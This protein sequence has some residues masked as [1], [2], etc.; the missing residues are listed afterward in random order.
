MHTE[1][2]LLVEQFFALLRS[3]DNSPKAQ[4]KLRNFFYNM[5]SM[6]H[7]VP[8]TVEFLTILKQLKPFLHQEFIH[9][10]VPNS[11]IHMMAHID[12]DFKT[13]L[14]NLGI[15]SD[16]DLLQQLKNNIL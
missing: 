11:R 3:L 5:T 6:K 4:L 13:A 9:S 10:L 16:A 1:K 15:N 12:L 8:P 7:F 2:R 14:S